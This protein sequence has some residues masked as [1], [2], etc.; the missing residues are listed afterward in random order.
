[1]EF[2]NSADSNRT[3]KDAVFLTDSTTIMSENEDVNWGEV[4]WRET[5]G[6]WGRVSCDDSLRIRNSWH[7]IPERNMYEI[8]DDDHGGWKDSFEYR[9]RVLASICYDQ[10]VLFIISYR[11]CNVCSTPCHVNE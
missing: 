4:S 8:E 7:L 11:Y 3:R 10:L 2:P 5:T 9:S 1:M 6:R